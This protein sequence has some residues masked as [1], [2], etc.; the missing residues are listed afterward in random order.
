VTE[1]ELYDWALVSMFVFAIITALALIFV[2]APY[3]RHTRRGW[4]PEIPS[5]LGWIVME[6]PSALLFA[7]IF[8][9]G[10]HRAQTVPLILLAVWQFHYLHRTFVFPF[11]MR[12]KGKR[13]PVLIAAMAIVF[14]VL[15][16]YVNARWISHFGEYGS[17]WLTD[18][19]FLA[20]V[21]LFAAGF[22]INFRADSVLFRLRKPGE[23]GY[24]IP[25]GGMHDL[26]V[27]PNYLGEIVEWMGWALLTW[28]TAGLSFAVYTIANLAP[29]AL[30][31]LRWYRGEFPD[32]PRGRRALIPW[33]W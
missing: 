19:R 18:P 3:G 31:N 13:M 33:V 22:A 27:A 24:K 15:N 30:S 16:S 29:R 6:S 12:I 32:F 9:Q 11:R 1:P 8:F 23:S 17:E 5:R 26:V 7:W 2:T 20:G 28:S 21:G 14:N 4:G 25:H 10:D